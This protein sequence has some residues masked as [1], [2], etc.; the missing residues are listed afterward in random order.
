MLAKQQTEHQQHIA[1]K[2]ADGTLQRATFGAGCFWGVEYRFGKIEGVVETAVG[3]AGG[4]TDFP[5]YREVCGGNT[6][7]AEVVE[8]LYDPTVISYE[9]L[10]RAFFE[11]HDPTTPNRQGW[12]VGSQYRSVIF[13]HSEDQKIAAEKIKVQLNSSGAYKSPIVTEIAEEEPFFKAE[14]YHQK[15]SIKNNHFAC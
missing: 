3:Y 10:V 6:G 9:Q 12:D 5:T 1:E 11:M 15:Y 2:L 14:E 7:H 8:L 4:K 13:Y